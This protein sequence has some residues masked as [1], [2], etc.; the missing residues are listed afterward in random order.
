M[1]RGIHM[2]SFA[3]A[4]LLSSTITAC[5]AQDVATQPGN[6]E[7]AGENGQDGDAAKADAAHD[8]FGFIA[9]EKSGAFDC[10]S[11]LHCIQYN[12]TRVNRTTIQ[13]NDGQYHDKC[14]VKSIVW[15]KAGL[16]DAQAATVQA[17]IDRE[18]HDPTLGVQVLVKGSYR[19]YVDF[20]A[21]EPSEVWLAQVPAGSANG[22]F[23]RVFDRGIRCITAPCP[24]FEEDRLNS[25]R[26]MVIDAID[27]PSVM[28]DS[29]QEQ[30]YA[31][32]TSADGVII[33]GDRTTHTQ[34]RYIEKFRSINQV[35]LP[36]K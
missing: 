17:A 6:D 26:S 20:L 27:Y 12:L 9:V 5:A 30:V 2:R 35:Y 28:Q 18:A 10:Q 25:N 3:F 19:I 1:R 15:S 14:G 21:F 32:T 29:L 13:C 8:N 34:G 31:A 36:V 11:P 23:V 22:T 24:Q 16:S 7:L 33:A 4:L